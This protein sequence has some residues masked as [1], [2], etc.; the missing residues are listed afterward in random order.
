MATLDSNFQTIELGDVA[1]YSKINANTYYLNHYQEVTA[2]YTCDTGDAAGIKDYIIGV[3]TTGGAVTVKLPK[4][5]DNSVTNGGRVLHILKIKGSSNVTI[6]TDSGA[7]SRDS[8]N[9][10]TTTTEVLTQV[11]GR[12]TVISAGSAKGWF[13]VHVDN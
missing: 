2:D 8:F 11:G 5:L 9:G 13:G 6:E 4:L 1:W 10:G 7:T 12:C 3:D